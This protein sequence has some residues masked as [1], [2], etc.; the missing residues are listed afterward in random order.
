MTETQKIDKND[1]Q[2]LV[3]NR[4]VLFEKEKYAFQGFK[5]QEDFPEIALK[6]VETKRR[7]DMEINH[8]YKQLITYAV[9][10]D[11]TTNK[12][13]LYKRLSGSGE[14]RL[15]NK[16][17]IGV[18]GHANPVL[19]EEL[20]EGQELPKTFDELMAE[21]F[22][23]ELH[24]ELNIQGD[25]EVELLGFVNDDENEVG[26]VHVGVIYLVK[27]ES[28]ANVSVN[29]TD[30]L[31]IQFVTFDEL[32]ADDKLEAWSKLLRDSEEIKEKIE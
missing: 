14:S 16:T 26:E 4:E 9:I 8:K 30:T 24:E 2:I 7:G 5:P 28:E 10:Q 23:R 22:N 17:S 13:L 3:V 11:K 20:A 25:V 31:E 29:E 6:T 12:L 1:E 18:G 21:N 15:V 19:A 32:Q 27:V